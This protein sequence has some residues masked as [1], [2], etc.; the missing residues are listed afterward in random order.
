[1]DFLWPK[2]RLVV[3][4]DGVAAHL[5]PRA[6]EHDRDRDQLLAVHGFG[7]VRFTWRQVVTTPDLVVARLGALLGAPGYPSPASASTA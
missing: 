6:S 5:V 1:M 3:E 2:Q 4:T 7:V